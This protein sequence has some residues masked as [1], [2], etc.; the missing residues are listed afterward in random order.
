MNNETLLTGNENLI[1]RFDDDGE[2]LNPGDRV[3]VNDEFEATISEIDG[4][5]RLVGFP[6][7][8]IVHS[9]ERIDEQT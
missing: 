6:N 8:E 5:R 2:D 7:D 9:I 3:L 4:E 1:L